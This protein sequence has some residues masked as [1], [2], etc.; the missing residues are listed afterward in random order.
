MIQPQEL[1]SA[2]TVKANRL[3]NYG[4]L[5]FISLSFLNQTI[6]AV[7]I[8]DMRSYGCCLLLLHKSLYETH[9]C[10]LNKQ[11]EQNHACMMSINTNA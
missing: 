5:G 2:W 6:P 9:L 1:N 4:L 11:P 7:K 8:G 3:R 10:F